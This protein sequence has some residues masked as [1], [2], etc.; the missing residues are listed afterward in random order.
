MKKLLIALCSVAFFLSII[1]LAS[2]YTFVDTNDTEKRVYHYLTGSKAW[3]ELELPNLSNTYNPTWQ[4]NS[5]YVT[6][7]DITLTYKDADGWGDIEIYLDDGPSGS[8]PYTYLTKFRPDY[9]NDTVSKEFAFSMFDFVNA[10]S[11]D[12]L[13][14]FLIGYGCHFTHL[15]TKVEIAQ[16]PI[17]APIILLG[18]GLIGL[19]AWRRKKIR[20]NSQPLNL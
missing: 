10:S 17:P 1:E 6:M 5:K 9:S 16:T 3:F 4:Y 20:K 8:I 18:S 7:F 19:A 12:G 11:F 15:Q 2:A 13:S 14:T